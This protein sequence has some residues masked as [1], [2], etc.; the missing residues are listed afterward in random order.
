[1]D[2]LHKRESEIDCIDRITRLIS[3]TRQGEQC[4]D[5]LKIFSN[6]RRHHFDLST[7]LD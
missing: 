6:L 7:S 3:S 5:F 4:R 1:M 2:L